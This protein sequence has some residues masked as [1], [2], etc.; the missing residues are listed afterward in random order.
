MPEATG[1]TR[2]SA[3]RQS[4]GDSE[5][6][7]GAKVASAILGG[8]GQ[9]LLGPAACRGT[10]DLHCLKGE[11]PGDSIADDIDS[12]WE[13]IIVL[14]RLTYASRG[15]M[16]L[17]RPEFVASGIP[18][19]KLLK[20]G[21]RTT[22]RKHFR[23]CSAHAAPGLHFHVLGIPILECRMWVLCLPKSN[24]THTSALLHSLHALLT[25]TLPIFSNHSCGPCPAI[26]CS[27]SALPSYL[28][29]TPL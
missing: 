28:L 15:C 23:P 11:G 12:L 29:R 8:K 10:G 13:A 24:L 1:W 22:M 4:P 7:Q 2:R 26:P 16:G 9:K 5:R 20:L 27:G 17:S 6:E 3:S 25:C 21:S 18:S 14:F 19:S